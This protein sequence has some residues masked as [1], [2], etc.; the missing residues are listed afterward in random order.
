MEMK[1]EDKIGRKRGGISAL[2]LLAIP[3]S[4]FEKYGF[5]VSESPWLLCKMGL[6]QGI[7]FIERVF[8]FCIIL[9]KI[10]NDYNSNVWY[11]LKD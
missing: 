10:L 1:Q 9:L 6:V 7:G 11:Q 5:F 2:A 3:Q 8:L 4:V